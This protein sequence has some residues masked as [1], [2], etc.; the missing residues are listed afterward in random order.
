MQLSQQEPAMASIGHQILFLVCK[1]LERTWPWWIAKVGVFYSTS[2]L[3]C[4]NILAQVCIN[5]LSVPIRSVT[6]VF[7]S[8]S[9]FIFTK[10]VF[11]VD[12]NFFLHFLCFDDLVSRLLYKQNGASRL[13][14]TPSVSGVLIFFF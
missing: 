3:L 10:D 5:I 6:Q 7:K 13:S 12:F 9:I 11:G 2:A 8:I 4:V 14:G 1:Q